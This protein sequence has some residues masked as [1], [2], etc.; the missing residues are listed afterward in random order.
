[1]DQLS[2]ELTD[3]IVAALS[4]PVSS[5]LSASNYSIILLKP[6]IFSCSV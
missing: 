5:A 3:E 6:D 2:F 4:K 1:M